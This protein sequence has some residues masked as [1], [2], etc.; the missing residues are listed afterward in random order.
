MLF[1]TSQSYI[2]SKD[3]ERISF[4]PKEIYLEAD[5]KFLEKRVKII[6]RADTAIRIKKF[7]PSCYCT[8]VKLLSNPVYT[9]SYA[10]VFI[11]INTEGIEG[12]SSTIVVKAVSLE[13]DTTELKIHVKKK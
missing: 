5:G 13:E 6:N 8:N 4:A 2:T 9:S 10:E 12:D 1:I 11:Q 7:I 3:K